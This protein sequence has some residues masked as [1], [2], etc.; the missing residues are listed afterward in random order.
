[1]SQQ[2]LNQIITQLQGLSWG[3][4]P[5][6]MRANFT[7]G[8][9]M[10]PH[11]TAQVERVDVDG[12]AAE[13][14]T[15]PNSRSD[16]IVLYLHGGGFIMGSLPAYRRLASDLAEAAG[17]SILVID[18]R[19]AP[20]HPYPAGLEDALTAYHWLIHTRGFQPGQIAVT[21]DS[22]GGNL[23]LG[24]L[25]SLKDLGELQP[26]CVSLIS[27]YCD[28]MRT[29]AT[30]VSHAKKDLMV[31]APLLD[32]IA[33]W[34]APGKDLRSPLLSPLYADLSGLPPL[35]IHVGAVEVLLD[36]A[37][38]LARQAGLAD[39][40]VTL[41]VWSDMIH[42]FHLF[43]P[44]LEEGRVAISEIGAFLTTGFEFNSMDTLA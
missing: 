10:P 12:M 18:Y 11:P 39:I 8:L 16:R 17:V 24:L 21:G 41:K 23:V 37:L 5:T 43:A 6:E 32:T 20:E 35:L 4:T 15:H 1:M 2:E 36:D 34:Y 9:S 40:P 26:A 38:R 27:P 30:M 42:C 31:T 28:Q 25:L 7:M 19:L 13:L 14:I 44:V 22:A 33:D 3:N 29:G